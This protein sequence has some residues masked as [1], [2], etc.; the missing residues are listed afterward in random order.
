MARD[1]KSK[2]AVQWGGKSGIEMNE[3]I[4]YELF[5]KNIYEILLKQ[6]GYE[7]VIVQHN[8]KLRGISG[9][10]HQIDVYWEFKIA[11][12]THKVA[13]ECK[14]YSSSVS[15]GKIRDFASVIEDLKDVKGIMVTK[16]GYQE[17]AEKFAKANKIDIKI[18]REP[19]P[20]DWDGYIKTIH[21]TLTIIQNT[22]F[23]YDFEFDK[24][25]IKKEKGLK[26]GDSYCFK[27]NA[28]SNNVFIDNKDKNE[29]KNLQDYI[30][31]L[32]G[33][34]VRETDKKWNIAFNEAY[35]VYENER[36]KIK[37][38][39][40]T[41]DVVVFD[42]ELVFDAQEAVKAIIKDIENDRTTFINY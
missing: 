42:D 18:L 33:G 23:K 4:D 32:P 37:S 39:T 1:K 41:Y 12:I 20:S 19:I 14:N 27:I 26:S 40:I 15:I 29:T 10:E 22:H 24:E 2:H 5:A 34:T 16:I 13:V 3:N 8:V 9:C 11:G 21:T 31:K 28:L 38:M 25:W 30:A 36:L 35:L 7:N 17:G 6:E